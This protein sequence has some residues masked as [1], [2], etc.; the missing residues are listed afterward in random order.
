M[1]QTQRTQ[2]NRD[3]RS[4]QGVDEEHKREVR[5]TERQRW[6]AVEDNVSSQ[7]IDL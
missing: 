1:G 3:R 2:T 5:D 7:V 6:N 4:N